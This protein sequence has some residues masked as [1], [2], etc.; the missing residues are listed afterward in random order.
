MAGA[1]GSTIRG[2]VL[3]YLSTSRVLRVDREAFDAIRKYAAAATGRG[4]LPSAG[5]VLDIL[6]STALPVDRELGG[7]PADLRGRVRTASLHDA[8]RSLAEMA[9]EYE[10]AADPVRAA[11][12]RRAVMHTKKH[13]SLALAGNIGDA[14]R[15]VKQEVLLWLRVWLENPEVFEVWHAL[16][17]RESERKTREREP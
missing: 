2:A 12:V 15:A 17:S 1:Q 9:H 13:V 10:E 4:R 14:K 7:F 11:D 8:A 5:Y 3:E 16:R 6:L